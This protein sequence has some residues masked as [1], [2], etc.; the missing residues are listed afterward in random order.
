MRTALYA[1]GVMNVAAA[2]TFLPAA[3]P[4]R[5]LIGLPEYGHPLYA[6]SVAMFIFLFGLGYLWTARTGHADRV[7]I[8]V[9]AA[10]KF[11]FFAT[12]A[13][14]WALGS[15]PLRA[16]LLGCADLFFSI[17]FAVWL[18]GGRP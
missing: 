4:V 6:A 9:A 2:A 18:F 15:L 3:L 7:F 5:T 8:A 11:S 1:T 16:P 10:G 17:V 14:F 12:L 13:C